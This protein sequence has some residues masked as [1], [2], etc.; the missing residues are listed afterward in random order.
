MNGLSCRGADLIT[1]Q[2]TG[3]LTPLHVFLLRL[4]TNRLANIFGN[5]TIYRHDKQK[6]KNRTN[7]RNKPSAAEPEEIAKDFA[8]V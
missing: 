5:D 8:K 6:I 3:L 4:A 7:P 2:L 1:S